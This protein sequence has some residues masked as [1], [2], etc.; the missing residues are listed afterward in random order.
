MN[1]FESS[2]ILLYHKFSD[3]GYEAEN[4]LLSELDKNLRIPRYRQLFLFI[5]R[6]AYIFVIKKKSNPNQC[7]VRLIKKDITVSI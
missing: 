3:F 7:R 6:D 5:C 1:C 4:V 2:I